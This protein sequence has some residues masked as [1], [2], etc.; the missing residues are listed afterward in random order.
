M[1]W[2]MSRR[3]SLAVA[4]L[5]DPPKKHDPGGKVATALPKD[6]VGHAEFY[7]ENE[8]YRLWLDRDWGGATIATPFLLWVGMNPST[9][10]A[11]VNDPT[12]TREINFTKAWGYCAYVK[13]NVMDFRATNQADLLKPGVNPRSHRN[14]PTILDYAKRADKIVLC[15]GVPH[16]SLQW[17][18]SDTVTELRKQG[19]G[20]KLFCLGKTLLGHARHPLYLRA[21]TQLEPF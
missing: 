17:Y 20:S 12:I 11:E 9:A 10:T 16:K 5:F 15:Y 6:M 3:S 8:E 18:G 14:L 21:D 13:T 1:V 2:A 19:Y 4:D 7:G